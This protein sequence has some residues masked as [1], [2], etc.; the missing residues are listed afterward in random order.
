[1]SSAERRDFDSNHGTFYAAQLASVKLTSGDIDG[2]SRVI[3]KYFEET[4][5]DQIAKNG[6]QPLEWARTKPFHYICFNLEAMIVSPSLPLLSSPSEYICIPQTLAKLADQINVNYWTRKSRYG[7]TIQ[8]AVNYA[9]SVAPKSSK[10]EDVTQVLPHVLAA[11]AV[12]GDSDGKYAAFVK[13]WSPSSTP[14][15]E[16]SWWF[17]DQ[18]AAFQSNAL[19]G[20][21]KSVKF[22]RAG[23][24]EVP[25][26]DLFKCPGEVLLIDGIEVVELDVGLYVSCSDLELLYEV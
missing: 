4:F 26:G 25:V 5:P 22:A 24:N 9:M 20:K 14:Y 8:D 19:L 18:R 16:Q 17:Y 7:A 10:S 1:M 13:K 15:Q 21:A 23:T 6:N 11:D 2:A 12:Y 3:K